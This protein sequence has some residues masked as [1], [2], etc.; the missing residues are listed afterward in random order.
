MISFIGPGL[1][2]YAL[3]FGPPEYFGLLFFSLTALIT[4][5]EHHSSRD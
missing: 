5:L 1:A 3:K 4:F 2:K